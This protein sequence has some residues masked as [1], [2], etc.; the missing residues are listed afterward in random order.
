M[1][2]RSFIA[3]PVPPEVAEHL[4]RLN[5][6]VPHEAGRITWVKAPAIHLTCIFLGEI[7]EARVDSIADALREAA[8]AAEPFETNLDG[9]GAY[10]SF[11]RP[12]VVW[13][14]IA[15]GAEE[16]RMLKEGIDRALEPLGF[17]PDRRDYH[18]HITLG[19]VKQ[20]GQK[21]V[22]EHAAAD[23]VLPFEH[24]MTREVIL[25]R[26]DLTREGPIYTPLVRAPLGAGD[27]P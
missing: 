18:P 25:F 20:L 5:A 4:A 24:W 2:I 8:A 6:S 14:G 12:R 11:E 16:A 10:P 15:S 21:R 27:A 23:W 26:S 3:L 13:A 9:I 1:S 7:D 17:E 19:R 22:L